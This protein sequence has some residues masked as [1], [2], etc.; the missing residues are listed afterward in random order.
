MPGAALGALPVYEQSLLSK[1]ADLRTGPWP[2]LSEAK[3]R[4]SNK[5]KAPQTRGQCVSAS[6]RQESFFSKDILTDGN[7]TL[8]RDDFLGSSKRKLT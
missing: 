7:V 4:T 8:E 2:G 6:F 3:C 1:Q 5:A